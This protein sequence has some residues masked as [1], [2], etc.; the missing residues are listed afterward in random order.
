MSTIDLLA[1]GA[2]VDGD[3]SD[4][5]LFNDRLAGPPAG[6]PDSVRVLCGG[7]DADNWPTLSPLETAL[8]R[9]WTAQHQGYSALQRPVDFKSDLFKAAEEGILVPG[10]VCSFANK[11]PRDVLLYWSVTYSSIRQTSRF[12]PSTD[13]S[14]YLFLNLDGTQVD[15]SVRHMPI[16]HGSWFNAVSSGTSGTAVGL[17]PDHKDQVISRGRTWTG[18]RVLR[19]LAAG[20]HSFGI[21]VWMN[22]KGTVRVHSAQVWALV[23]RQ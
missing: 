1:T 2:A 12:A 9:R 19:N 6:A 14:H 3:V 16:S 8:H 10:V 22:G 23:R 18:H 15:G 21:A 13:A 20:E 11:E 7:M 17:N 4:V 5:Q